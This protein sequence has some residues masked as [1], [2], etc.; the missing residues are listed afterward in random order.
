MPQVYLKIDRKSR[1]NLDYG[2][3]LTTLF[4]SSLRLWSVLIWRWKVSNVW[5]QRIFGCCQEAIQKSSSYYRMESDREI[6]EQSPGDRN[7]SNKGL[8]FCCM[9]ISRDRRRKHQHYETNFLFDYIALSRW[10]YP[11]DRVKTLPNVLTTYMILENRSLGI[12]ID[13]VQ[14]IV[15]WQCPLWFCQNLDVNN[16]ELD[17]S[18]DCWLCWYFFLLQLILKVVIRSKI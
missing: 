5:C 18:V 11:V 14:I 7:F 8:D 13:D 17:K 15:C 3:K 4:R 2:S 10:K 6:L 12:Q 16:L 9:H 1:H